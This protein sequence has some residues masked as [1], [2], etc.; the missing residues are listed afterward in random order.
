MG[1]MA[2]KIEVKTVFSD[3]LPK[4]HPYVEVNQKFKSTFGGSNMVSIMVEV[5]KGDIFNLD[6]LARVQKLTVG[7]QQVD[8]VDTYQIVSIASKKIKEVRAS[9]EGVES[10]PIMWPELPKD[11]AA[12]AKLRAAVLNNTLVYGPYVS[13]DLKATLITADFRDGEINYSKAFEQIMSQVKEASGPGVKVRV[14]GEPVLYGWVNFYLD[15]TIKIFF[16][17]IASLIVILLLITRTWHGTLLPLLAG[18]ISAVWALGAADIMGFHLDPLVIV[19]AFLITAQAISNSV[20]LVSRY[21]DEIL[22]GATSS[23]AAAIASAK[24]LFKPSML[25]IFA[26]A[27]CV[28]VVALTPIPMLEKIS[29]IGTVWI[30]SILVSALLMTPVML[31]FVKPGQHFVH[32][33]N[34]RPVLEAILR[35]CVSVVTTSAR[36]VVLGLTLAG[37]RGFGL[38]RVQPEGGR[39]EPGLSDSLARFFVQRRRFRNQ[40]AVPGFGPDVRGGVRQGK[41]F[42][43]RAG[44]AAEHE[45]LPAL[46]G[47]SARSRRQHLF[48]G[49]P[50]RSSTRAA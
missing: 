42:A 43:A 27:G 34:I 46:H 1:I 33:I 26:D 44:S 50:S 14:V 49:H 19:V 28:L 10:K 21:D 16:A 13:L 36:Y 5:E 20:Q 12:M 47:G 40:P 31:S 35:V 3:L 11:D 17:A 15:E 22:R 4:N 38:V 29:Y 39:R 25:A 7:L 37:V 8:G 24:N 32:P 9:T 2:S 23:A 45:Q 30:F 48:G 6:V 41:G 18:S